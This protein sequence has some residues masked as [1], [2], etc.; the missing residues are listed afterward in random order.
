MVLT[1]STMR[2]TGPSV[3]VQG[4]GLRKRLSCSMIYASASKGSSLTDQSIDGVTMA[5]VDENQTL[6]LYLT[7]RGMMMTT[8]MIMAGSMAGV[9]EPAHA[10]GK[11][12]KE[13]ARE[14]K[15][16]RAKLK[17]TAEQMKSAGKASDAFASSNYS[18]PEEA[19]TPNVVNRNKNIE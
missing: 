7:R 18:V 9:V 8:M 5:S 1:S 17:E 14:A 3:V 6:S 2:T 4:R 11:S 12:A 19:T 10:F 15:Q 16:R 13:L